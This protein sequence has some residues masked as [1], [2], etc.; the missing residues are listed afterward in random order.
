LLVDESDQFAQTGVIDVDVG[1]GCF[2]QKEAESRVTVSIDFNVF[3]HRI[4]LEF[5]CIDKSTSTENPF[6]LALF[7]HFR[8]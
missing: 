8:R 6:I 5:K 3:C 2:V 1:N 7:L 4:L